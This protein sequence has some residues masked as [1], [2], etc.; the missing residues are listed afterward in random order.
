MKFS[1]NRQKG[2]RNMER[3]R[4]CYGRND[5]LTDGLTDEGHSYNLLLP[6]GGGLTKQANRLNQTFACNR[7]F[8]SCL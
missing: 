2:S 5:G 1:E 3:T 7:I 4:K 8:L 6:C